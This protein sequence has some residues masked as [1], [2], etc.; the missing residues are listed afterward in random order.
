M[1]VHLYDNDYVVIFKFWALV[2]LASN[3]MFCLLQDCIWAIDVI[4]VL[5]CKPPKDEVAR[6]W[7]CK[8][9]TTFNV[10]TICDINLCFT[11]A[12]SGYE[13]W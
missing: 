6:F 8:G 7:S 10:M 4:H 3:V 11:F 12:V 2:S 9:G 1:I 5:P 13:G